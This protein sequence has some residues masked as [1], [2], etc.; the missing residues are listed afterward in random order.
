MEV[1]YRGN[2]R[3][4]IVAGSRLLQGSDSTGPRCCDP[5][6]GRDEKLRV[7]PVCGELLIS[8]IR[9]VNSLIRGNESLFSEN[10]SLFR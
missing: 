8:L 5:A 9:S 4:F 7:E 2:S 6:N 10:D 3:N 1:R